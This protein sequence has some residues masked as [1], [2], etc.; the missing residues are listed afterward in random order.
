[1]AVYYCWKGISQKRVIDLILF[2]IFSALGFLTHYSFIFLLISLVAYYL[3]LILKKK[4]KVRR[5]FFIP[6]I[7]FFIL[8][9]PHIFW[10]IQNNFNTIFYAMDRTGLEESNLLNHLKNP[11]IFIFKQMGILSLIILIFFLILE[12]NRK[13]LKLNLLIKNFYS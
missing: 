13:K 6:L 1:M 4:I 3:F 2:G 11:V 12:N 7:I 5:I 9:L 10:L 8:L